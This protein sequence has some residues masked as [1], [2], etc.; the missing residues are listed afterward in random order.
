MGIF[1]AVIYASV[2]ALVNVSVGFVSETW[3]KGNENAEREAS[4][5]VAVMW[6]LTGSLTP[7]FGILIDYLGHRSTIVMLY[8]MI[9][10]RVFLQH[11][12]A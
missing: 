7:L 12:C 2:L 11:C 8:N 1:Y 6:F 4:K 10:N 5:M 3:L 9:M